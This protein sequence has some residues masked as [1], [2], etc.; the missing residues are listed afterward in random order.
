MLQKRIL[1]ATKKLFSDLV[2]CGTRQ[3]QGIPQHIAGTTLMPV[4]EMEQRKEIRS[5]ETKQL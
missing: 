1:G 2:F 3:S 5:S 4:Q